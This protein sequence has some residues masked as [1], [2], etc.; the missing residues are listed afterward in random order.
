[1]NQ[2]QNSGLDRISK[3]IRVNYLCGSTLALRL[4]H[5]G[6]IFGFLVSPFT[7]WQAWI[8][9]KTDKLALSSSAINYY[10]LSA[11]YVQVTKRYGKYQ[12]D[13]ET[14]ATLK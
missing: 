8:I 6:F 5:E 12:D 2:L 10:L 9:L 11:Y 3:T 13:Y 7:S 1:M 14:D 4:A